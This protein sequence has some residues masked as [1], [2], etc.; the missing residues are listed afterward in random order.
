[1]RR[2]SNFSTPYCRLCHVTGQPNNVTRSHRIGDPECPKLSQA[3]K[4]YIWAS[5][6]E[7]R[8]NAVNIADGT[9]ELAH[10]YGYSDSEQQEGDDNP[11]QVNIPSDPPANCH[12]NAVRNM[13]F[14]PP[15]TLIP[16]CNFIAP[17]P[18]QILTVFTEAQQ[19]F[20]IELDSNATVNYIKLDVAKHFNF[21]ICP[22][23][24]LSILADG[25]TKLPAVGEIYE[26]FFRND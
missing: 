9:E 3:D 4:E 19:P 13:F 8:V 15:E 5:R 1:M 16:S 11:D 14:R 26:Q 21:K 23:S 6:N 22:N 18:S 20:H 25:A 24:Q 2:H 12:T 10:E 7:P 17:V